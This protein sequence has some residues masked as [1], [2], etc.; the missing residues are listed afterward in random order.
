M[1]KKKQ[2]N[3]LD[4]KEIKNGTSRQILGS[5]DEKQVQKIQSKD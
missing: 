5:D 1:D 3:P 2:D 4:K